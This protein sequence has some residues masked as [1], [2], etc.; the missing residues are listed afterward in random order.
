V[1]PPERIED[2]ALLVP[3]GPGLGIALD[4]AVVIPHRI[5]VGA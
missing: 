2:G 5:D 1:V 4:E 3:T